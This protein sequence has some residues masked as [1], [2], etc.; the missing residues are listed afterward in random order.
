MIQSG[1]DFPLSDFEQ[2]TAETHVLFKISKK[3]KETEEDVLIRVQKMLDSDK[4]KTEIKSMVE[5]WNKARVK[6][7]LKPFR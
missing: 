5:R 7:G 6:K 2:V 4:F 1:F 3:D